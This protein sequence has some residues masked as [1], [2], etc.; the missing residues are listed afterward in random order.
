[1]NKKNSGPLI[2]LLVLAIIYILILVFISGKQGQNQPDYT[3][4]STNKAGASLFYDTLRDLGYDV[5]T[6]F[7]KIDEE[8]SMNDL[9]VV[10]GVDHS[11][12]SEEDFDLLMQWVYAGGSLL[13]FQEDDTYDMTKYINA[14]ARLEKNNPIPYGEGTIYLGKVQDVLNENF[15]NDQHAG[16]EMMQ[17]VDIHTFD[18]MIFNEYYHGLQYN[19]SLW[20]KLPFDFK[21]VVVQLLIVAI[22]LIWHLGKRF[23]KPIPYYEEVER[24]ENEYLLALANTYMGVNMQFFAIDSYYQ[25]FLRT[26]CDY[27]RVEYGEIERCLVEVWQKEGLAKLDLLINVQKRIES[28]PAKEVKNTKLLKELTSNIDVLTALVRRK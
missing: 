25:H 11:F 17:A 1:M 24:E 28:F 16:Y 23:G 3:I 20:E 9:Q 7:S 22:V 15:M 8:T 2:M 27:F 5:A 18:K 26:C 14:N 6:S 4:Y 13:Y 10:V 21:I 12:C 19:K